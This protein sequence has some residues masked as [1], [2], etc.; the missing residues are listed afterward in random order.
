M[1]DTT[2]LTDE[3]EQDFEGV[4]VMRNRLSE[5]EPETPNGIIIDEPDGTQRAATDEEAKTWADIC[6]DQGIFSEDDP[7]VILARTGIRTGFFL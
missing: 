3:I 6:V 2:N 5:F 1:S 4:D 7:A